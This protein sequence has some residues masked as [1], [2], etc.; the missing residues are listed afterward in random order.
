MVKMKKSPLPEGVVIKSPKDYQGGIVFQ[1]LLDDCYHKCYICEHKPIPLE[2]EH[3]VAHRGDE[4][5]RYDWNN[6]FCAC[7][8]CNRIK[9]QPKFYGGIIDPTQTDPEEY[10]ELHMDYN[11]DLREKIVI[12][13][14]VKDN[15]LVDVTVELLD[16]VYNNFST[17]NR[18]ESS[19]NLR[20]SVSKD[21]SMFMFYIGEYLKNPDDT[22]A[23]EV[24]MDEISRMSEFAAFKRQIIRDKGIVIK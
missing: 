7:V 17:D 16:L 22:A 18:K 9:N 1:L 8:H 24:I 23:C 4:K 20:N 15:E 6:L 21:I 3:R 11:E 19:F 13:K 10:I 2:V 12:V 14:K 5:L